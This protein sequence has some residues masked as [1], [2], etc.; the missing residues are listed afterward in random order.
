MGREWTGKAVV[1]RKGQ[2][3]RGAD[4][5][6]RERSGLEGTGL[7]RSGILPVAESEKGKGIH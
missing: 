1:E 4:W 6:G 5:R 7:E 3:G 2:D